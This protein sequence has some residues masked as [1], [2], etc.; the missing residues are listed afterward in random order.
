MGA[1]RPRQETIALLAHAL[2]LTSQERAALLAWGRPVGELSAPGRRDGAEH[3]GSSV[4]FVGRSADL[5]ALERHVRGAGVPLLVLAGEPGIGKSRLLSEAAV[6]GARQG[7]VVL[8][9]GCHQ[10]GGQE[11]YAPVGDALVRY[12]RRLS[13]PRAR[14]ELRGCAWLVKLVPELA[15]G[16]IEPL[17]VWTVSP[18]QERRLSFAAAAR[19]LTNAGGAGGALLLLD[20]LQWAGPDTLDLL[21][22]LISDGAATGLRLV[23]AYRDTEAPAGPLAQLLADLAQAGAA[24]QRTVGPLAW[25]EAAHLLRSLVGAGLSDAP[26]VAARE[27]LLPC[28][29]RAVLS[30]EL[31]PGLAGGHLYRGRRGRG[32]HLALERGT[33]RAPAGGGSAQHRAGGARRGRGGRPR[34]AASPA[35]DHER[36][37]RGGG[38]GRPGGSLSGPFA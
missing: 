19:F 10:R 22:T 2:A 11:P 31:C 24:L 5:A 3:P 28:R 17:P 15:D 34:G 32:R 9:G 12:L 38:A 13:V 1:H 18:R 21:R 23:A 36:I 37:S 14:A 7:R 35:R 8:T 33:R 6:L 4:P 16:P 27:Q 30:G 20:D 26:G 29:R 25:D